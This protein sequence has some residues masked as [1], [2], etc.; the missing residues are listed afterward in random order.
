MADQNH[1]NGN[2][3][4]L[5]GQPAIERW[6]MSKEFQLLLLGNRLRSRIAVTNNDDER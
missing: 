5:T 2:A 6:S 1:A 3:R 4:D